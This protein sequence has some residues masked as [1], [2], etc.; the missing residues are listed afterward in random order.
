MKRLQLRTLQPNNNNSHHQENNNE[1]N[2]K[3]NNKE[4]N[5]EYKYSESNLIISMHLN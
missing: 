5:T 3:N 1:N 2:N 4:I